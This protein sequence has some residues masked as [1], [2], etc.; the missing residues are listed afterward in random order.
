MLGLT[1]ELIKFYQLGG[2][3]DSEGFAASGEKGEEGGV[4]GL[5]DWARNNAKKEDVSV[6][7]GAG[8]W[9]SSFKDGTA[10]AAIMHSVRPGI[11]NFEATKGMVNACHCLSSVCVVAPT[12]LIRFPSILLPPFEL[13][14]PTMHLSLS[15]SISIP[16][17]T[18]AP[19]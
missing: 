19:P 8:A 1:W 10:F 9:T 7:T 5:L 2:K 11:I 14:L 4:A 6:G 13:F 15:S 3:T 17:F 12:I 16:R 18:I